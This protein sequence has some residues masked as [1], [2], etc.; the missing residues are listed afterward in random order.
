MKQQIRKDHEMR[1]NVPAILVAAIVMFLAGCRQP[2]QQEAPNEKQARLLAAQSADLQKQLAAKD[3]EIAALGRKQAQDH[4][5]RDAE[6]AQCKTRIEAL[7]ED[8]EKGIAERVSSLTTTVM[9]ENARLR[10]EIEQLKSEIQDLK[11]QPR[12]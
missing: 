1:S 3:A 2:Q 8:V 7:Q 12:P 9:E 11:N 5:Q 6:L 10:R 4:Q